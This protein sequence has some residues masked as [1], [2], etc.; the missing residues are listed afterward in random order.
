VYFARR[1]TVFKG[2]K[3]FITRGNVIDL[4]VAIVIG[5][6]FAALINQL[7]K[8][9]LEPLVRLILGGH[10]AAG[11]FKIRDQVFDYGAFINAV[12][13]FLI[14]ALAIYYLVVLPLNKMIERRNARLGLPPAEDEASAEVRLLTEIRDQLSRRP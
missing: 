1:W 2:F 6:A 9:F 3:E 8:S 5:T 13:T 4:A 7:T 10:N 14:T 11:T 12:I